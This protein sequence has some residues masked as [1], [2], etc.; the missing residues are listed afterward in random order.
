MSDEVSLKR[1]VIISI[2]LHLL[3]LLLPFEMFVADMQKALAQQS[4]PPEEMTFV[5]VET[6]ENA[7]ES[8][9]E[10]VT[11]FISDKNLAAAN[12]VAPGDLPA[13]MP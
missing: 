11:P 12:P 9:V 4:K 3:F 8:P 5:F 1:M 10:Q 13:G 7:E 2:L 6:P